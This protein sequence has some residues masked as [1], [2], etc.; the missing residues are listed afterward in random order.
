MW[1]IY[2]EICNKIEVFKIQY[3]PDIGNVVDNSP[4]SSIRLEKLRFQT[5]DDDIRKYPKF[6][7]EFQKYIQPLCKSD[8]IAFILRSY[9]IDEI[10]EEVDSLGDDI[11]QIWK[12]LDKKYGDHAGKRVHAIM[13]EIK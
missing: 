3:K 8:E 7:A 1:D 4:S 2:Y 13:S 6:K 11:D 10:S 12:R 5:F 9:L